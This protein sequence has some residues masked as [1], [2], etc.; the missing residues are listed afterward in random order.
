MK[1]I[2]ASVNLDL[3][4]ILPRPMARIAHAAKLEFSSKDRSENSRSS[5]RHPAIPLPCA[6]G[7][8]HAD[9]PADGFPAR[10]ALRLG[11]LVVA[12]NFSL[13]QPHADHGIAARCRLASVVDALRCAAEVR[14]GMAEYPPLRGLL[15]AYLTRSGRI[16]LAIFFLRRAR[17][18]N[19]DAS[20]LVMRSFAV[21]TYGAILRVLARDRCVPR[22]LLVLLRHSGT[23]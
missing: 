22:S 8:P 4:M 2:C 14:R 21:V 17:S 9:Q 1:A 18:A 19:A 5:L 12:G 6:K 16:A 11:P 10:T 3:F 20:F 23:C 13:R 15:M 7:P